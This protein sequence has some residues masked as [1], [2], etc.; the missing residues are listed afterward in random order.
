MTAPDALDRLREVVG[1]ATEDAPVPWTL[2]GRRF[3]DD[4]DGCL[5]E[6]WMYGPST[7]A[8]HNAFGAL[9][10]R[11][12]AADALIARYEYLFDARGV[13][14]DSVTTRRQMNVDAA[15]AA[16]EEAVAR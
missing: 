9:Y 5:V 15:R 14:F 13:H 10:E 2:D 6:S 16:L 3:V 8:L 11:V 4:A 1:K 7:V 12:R